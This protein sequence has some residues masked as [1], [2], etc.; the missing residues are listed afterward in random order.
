MRYILLLVLLL[1]SPLGAAEINYQTDDGIALYADWYPGNSAQTGTIVLFHQAG[2]SARGEYPYIS[3]RLNALGFNVL[4]VDQRSGGDRFGTGNRTV[5]ALGKKDYGYCEAWPD[6]FASIDAARQRSNGPVL[7]WGS[8]YSAGLVLR[9]AAM[10]QHMVDAVLA[11]SPAASGPMADCSPTGL[12]HKVAVPAAAF[13]P[14]SEMQN[15]GSISQA[16]ELEAAGIIFHVIEGGVHGSS[17]LVP[18]R[19]G[20]D[21]EA[22]WRLVE[23]FIQPFLGE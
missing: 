3:K 19:S 6:L 4:A 18:E 22:A 2:G 21:I 11:F 20:A 17:M 14:E 15:P 23:D 13:R 12:L 1:G 7:I 9:L 8:S 16:K 10:H 5:E